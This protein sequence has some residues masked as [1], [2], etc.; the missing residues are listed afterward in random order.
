MSEA[1]EPVPQFLM[2]VSDDLLI[3][4][5]HQALSSRERGYFFL[6]SS[7]MTRSPALLENYTSFQASWNRLPVDTPGGRLDRQR[8]LS[9]FKFYPEP[10]SVTVLPD[11]SLLQA[12]RFNAVMGDVIRRYDPL[13]PDILESSLLQE[14][15]KFQFRL[16][17]LAD[18]AKQQSWLIEVH[19]IRIVTTP[20]RIGQPT[21][22]GR[23][24]EGWEFAFHTLFNR[25]NVAGAES[26]VFDP[27]ADHEFRV[28]DTRED[29]SSVYD[30]ERGRILLQH[31]FDMLILWDE[32]VKHGTTPALPIFN[33]KRGTRD[34]LLTFFSR[35]KAIS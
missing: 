28:V 8:R 4:K 19:Q 24:R 29:G 33:S 25:S 14:L 7:C 5:V 10:A 15:I 23:H 31:P 18:E 35:N 20:D 6:P 11:T 30:Y 32:A 13:E 3:L 27:A 22:Y 12:K 2:N 16:L 26:I 17:P 1:I 9:K 21:P 34:M